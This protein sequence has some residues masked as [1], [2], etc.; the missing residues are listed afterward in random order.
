MVDIGRCLRNAD[1]TADAL[2]RLLD[3]EATNAVIGRGIN[4]APR[5]LVVADDLQ[6]LIALFPRVDGVVAKM[7]SVSAGS[8]AR[9]SSMSARIFFSVSCFSWH[10]H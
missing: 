8:I 4:D 6:G 2:D 7:N 5:G 3:A 9:A 10:R 1:R